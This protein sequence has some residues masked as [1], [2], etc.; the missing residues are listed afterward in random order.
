M[1]SVGWTVPEQRFPSDELYIGTFTKGPLFYQLKIVRLGPNKCET[2][3]GIV[4][5]ER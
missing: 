3:I 5:G 1:N 4:Y 2:H